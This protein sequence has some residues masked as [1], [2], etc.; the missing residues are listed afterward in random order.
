MVD[1]IREQGMEKGQEKEF[2]EAQ[3]SAVYDLNVSVYCQIYGQ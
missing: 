2:C 3:E 1:A